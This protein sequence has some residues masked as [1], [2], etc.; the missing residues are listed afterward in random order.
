MTAKH[1][2]TEKKLDWAVILSTRSQLNLMISWES[3]FPG[4]FFRQSPLEMAMAVS[5]V[6]LLKL[7]APS[8]SCEKP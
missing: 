7:V 4:L 1:G 2:K 5:V 8:Q 3:D 6:R